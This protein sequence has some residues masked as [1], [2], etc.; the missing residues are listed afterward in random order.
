MADRRGSIFVGALW[1]VF[2][3]ILLFWL[4]VLGAFVAGLV[5]GY[6]A[7]GVGPGLIAAFAPAAVLG[8]LLF[9]L[10]SALTGLPLIGAVAGIGGTALAL[11]HDGPLFVGA[12]VGGLLSE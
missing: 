8:G 10:A 5:G 2:L 11:I 9:F 4:P 6:K 12:V 1:M 7:G 3:S